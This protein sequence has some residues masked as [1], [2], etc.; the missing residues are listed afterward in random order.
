MISPLNALETFHTE[1]NTFL[2]RTHRVFP[3]CEETKDLYQTQTDM[4]VTTG[5]TAMLN[6][7]LRVRVIKEWHAS[8]SPFYQT[9]RDRDIIPLLN[10][11]IPILRKIN[12][13]KKWKEIARE[14]RSTKTIIDS[15]IVLNQL[16]VLYNVV[17]SK[18]VQLVQSNVDDAQLEKISE[19]KGSMK[20]VPFSTIA[21]NVAKNITEEDIE[22]IFSNLGDL[23]NSIDLDAYSDGLET[24]ELSLL[25]MFT[26]G[27][28][29][30]K[31]ETKKADIAIVPNTGKWK[32]SYR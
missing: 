30:T 22:H 10:A 12:F 13:A 2:K 3:E 8:M 29:P 4:L 25:S 19:G 31:K 9:C 18:I 15:I 7:E 5:P 1:L 32:P 11:N 28:M 6:K 14:P 24:K 27:N 26:G 21:T 17:P 20:D 23:M 16:A